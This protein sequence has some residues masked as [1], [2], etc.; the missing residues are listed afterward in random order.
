MNAAQKDAATILV[1]MIRS[2]IAMMSSF[3]QWLIDKYAGQL[4]ANRTQVRMESKALSPD[5]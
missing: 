2:V 3:D 1:L 4:P 5:S